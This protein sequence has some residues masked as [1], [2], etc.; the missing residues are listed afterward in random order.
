MDTKKFT[1][2]ISAL[3]A[4]ICLLTVVYNFASM[5]AYGDQSITETALYPADIY[6]QQS[7]LSASSAVS[8]EHSGSTQKGSADNFKNADTTTLPSNA[9]LNSSFTGGKEAATPQNPINL[10]TA[11]L[12][13]L[14]SV[15]GIGPVK[16]QRILDYRSAHGAF[17]SIDELDNVKGFGKKTVSKVR[18]YFKLN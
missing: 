8:S 18:P 7:S 14:E 5:P 12:A 6:T 3:T 10:N 15:P 17:K 9:P 13:E 11:T 16:A 1:L 2:L 4:V